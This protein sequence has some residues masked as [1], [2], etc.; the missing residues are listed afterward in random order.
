MN[1]LIYG[2]GAVGLGIASCLI[3]SQ[4]AVDIIARPQTVLC[5]QMEGLFRKGIFGSFFA[6]SMKFG[7]YSSLEALPK[8]LYDYILVCTKSY[9]TLR[10]AQD[11]SNHRSCFDSN[12]R[13]ILFQN[14]W[15]NAEIF[16]SFF[17]KEQIFSARVITGFTRPKPNEVFI[18]VHADAVHIGSLFAAASEKIQNLC[19]AVSQGGIPC[20][21]TETIE[22]DL[23]A[24]MLYNCALNPLGAILNVPYGALA[25][26]ESARFIMNSIIREIFEV[27][28]C[29]G[30]RTHWE[31]ADSF[32]N[33]FYGRLVP[34]TAEH[35]SSTLQDMNAKKKTEI[36]ALNGAVIRLAEAHH[37]QVPYNQ[38]LYHIIKF[39]EPPTNGKN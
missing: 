38:T 34:D 10:A 12:T 6:P 25:E 15:G 23:W 35:C 33:V 37:I 22:K 5:L 32:L 4:I 24:K 16:A 30:Y 7:A 13:F 9:D 14:G 8:R 39:R 3:R 31:N 21:P 28:A 27:L 36:D 19:A 29:T 18:T 1:V 20:R 2:G 26:S 11:I 17:Q